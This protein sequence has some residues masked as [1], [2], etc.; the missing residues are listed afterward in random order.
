MS[1]RRG[2]DAAAPSLFPRIPARCVLFFPFVLFWRVPSA[3]FA[4]FPALSVRE[5]G[6]SKVTGAFS[7]RSSMEDGT[8]GSSPAAAIST[9]RR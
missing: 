9:R 6:M 5:G 2:A 8:R 3:F 1:G 7:S 4:F